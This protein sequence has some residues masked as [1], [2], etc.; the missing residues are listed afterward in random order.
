MSNFKSKLKQMKMPILLFC[1]ILLVQSSYSQIIKISN[2]FSIT[3]LKTKKF[4][5]LGTSISSYWGSIGI[6]Y[7][8]KK[9]FYMSSD[10]GYMRIGGKEINK[11]LPPTDSAYNVHQS[12][13]YG[14][15]STTFRVRSIINNIEY[16]LGAGP[17][18]NILLGSG[19]FENN[20]YQDYKLKK[21]N[22]GCKTEIG[23][24]ANI[25]KI[26]VGLNG[27]Y[28]INMSSLAKSQYNSFTYKA[29]VGALSVGYRFN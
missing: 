27:A 20:I 10:I 25:K 19:N 5:A 15:L 17:Y 3:N 11:N 28:F 16:Y 9:R 18:L 23:L 22:F 7:L 14:Q 12:F 13:N 2:G 8:D 21:S 26:R 4:D 1:C 24:T 29:F 6:E